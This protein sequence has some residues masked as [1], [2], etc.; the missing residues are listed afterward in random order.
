MRSIVFIPD[1]N[2]R[3]AKRNALQSLLA[4]HSKG[5]EV[6]RTLVETA[7]EEGVTHVV[8]LGATELN[9]KERSAEERNHLYALFKKYLQELLDAK[10]SDRRIYI[11]GNWS[12]YHS[13]PEL[14]SLV[15]SVE[16]RSVAAD[17]AQH[18]TF[19]FGHDGRRDITDAAERLTASGL[20]VTVE[21]ICRKLPTSHLGEIDCIFRSG[22]EGDPH[23]SGSLM[24]F[25]TGN[26]QFIFTEK[27][28][29]EVTA[30]YLR[31]AIADV[32]K[33]QRRLGK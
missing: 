27:L 17:S 18:L 8:F 21:S 6:A 16:S 20:K 22:V 2:R 9:L 24:P 1:G 5:A 13:D 32:R 4:G 23:N 11:R 12:E 30:D 26:S 7:L 10:R 3:F 14:A 28:W 19:L 29:P 25:Q 33:R 31:R 15:A